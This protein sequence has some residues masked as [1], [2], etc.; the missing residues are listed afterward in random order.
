MLGWHSFRLINAET[1]LIKTVQGVVYA[2]CLIS[3][4]F[5]EVTLR[6]LGEPALK[7]YNALLE[8]Y[9]MDKNFW[10][11][12][13]EQFITQEVESSYRDNHQDATRYRD[14]NYVILRFPFDDVTGVSLL[15]SC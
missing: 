15:I 5:E 14:K 7:K 10:N 6:H 4:N 13:I 2:S 11:A 12:L 9:E 3:D 1:L 8:Q